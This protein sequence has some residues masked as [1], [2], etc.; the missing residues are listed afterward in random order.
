MQTGKKK[1]MIKILTNFIVQKLPIGMNVTNRF[2][3][4]GNIGKEI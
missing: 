3:E 1:K 2:V 4:S